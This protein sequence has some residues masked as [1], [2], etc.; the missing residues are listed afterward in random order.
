L[1]LPTL[2]DRELQNAHWLFSTMQYGGLVK[3]G[4]RL[5]PLAMKMGLPVNGAHP[6]NHL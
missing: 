6:Q 3:L 2:S 1:L 4:T 5:T